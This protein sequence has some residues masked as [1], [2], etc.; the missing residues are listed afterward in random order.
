MD[1]FT[2]AAERGEDPFILIADEIEDPHNLG[3]LIRTAECAGCHGVIISKRRAVGVTE[4]V[5]K[6]SVGATEYVPIVRANNINEAIRELKDRGVWVV[7][8]DGSAKTMYYDQDMTGPIA[9]IIGSE[10]RGM[11]ELTMKNSDFLVKIPMMGKI[12]SLNASVSGGIVVFEA[13]R[14][15]LK[16]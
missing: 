2:L 10:G 3:A 14:Q 12:T 4:V 8:T 15:R 16:K 7:G 11:S 1:I 5:A 13:L 6:T 9:I